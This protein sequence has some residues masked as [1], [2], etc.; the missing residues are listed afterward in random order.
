[1]T[2]RPYVLISCAMSIDGYLDDTCERRLILSNEMDLDRVDAVRAECDAILVG[3]TT[4]RRDNPRLLVR[5]A[6]RRANR[7]ADGRSPS[8]AKVTL[9]RS[10]HC[11]PTRRFFADDGTEKLVYCYSPVTER[12]R[13]RLGDR[14]LVRD[15]GHPV[16]L[17][18]MLHDLAAS[19]VQR[20]MVEGGGAI[21]RQLLTAGLV[22]ELH[23]VVA[24][25]FVGD[26]AAPRF[27]HD[28]PY[29]QNAAS[30][31]KL[32]EARALGD[33]VLLRYAISDRYEGTPT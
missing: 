6:D 12:V 32:V 28:G 19:G 14:A 8:P 27:A 3:A 9:T 13:Q 21:H 7:T 24:P 29:P 30:P 1:M 31:A 4:I 22:D 20:L 17:R 25:F 16:D 33:V 5:S 23:L 11:D 2:R 15:G 10:G 18:W 26:S